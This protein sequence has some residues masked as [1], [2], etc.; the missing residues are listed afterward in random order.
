MIYKKIVVI[1]RYEQRIHSGKHP[2]SLRN[3]KTW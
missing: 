2:D 3:H 1:W